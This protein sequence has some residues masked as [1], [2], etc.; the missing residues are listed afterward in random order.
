M[1]NLYIMAGPNGAGKT[2]TAYTLLP[3]ILNVWEFVNADEIARGLSPFK[4]DS[5]AFEAGRI[6]LQRIDY[7]LNKQTD[8]AFE[9]TL[10]TRSYVSTIRRAQEAGYTVTLF[11]VYLSSAELAVKRVAKR[12]S[13][14]GHNIPTDVVHRRYERALRNL[15]S[16]YLPI[17][18][19]YLIVNNS[20]EEPVEVARGGLMG[21]KIVNPI[22]WNQLK[23]FYGNGN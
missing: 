12:V 18:D 9:T 22:V 15:F 21:E 17:C 5:V 7:L 16:L 13:I 19:S 8:F 3:E 20:G 6:M 1:P 4:V 14:G 11:F 23:T 2:T 10:S